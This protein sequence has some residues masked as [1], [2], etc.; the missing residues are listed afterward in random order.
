MKC[1]VRGYRMGNPFIKVFHLI[2][3]T[4]ERKLYFDRLLVSVP[5]L[6]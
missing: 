6:L 1:G 3:S 5:R 4:C 2:A